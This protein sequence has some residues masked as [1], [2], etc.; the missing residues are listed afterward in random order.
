MDYSELAEALIVKLFQYN[1][2]QS[3]KISPMIHGEIMTLN[4]LLDHKCAATPGAISGKMEL[5][6]A[7]VA[8]L[9]RSLEHRG[10][11]ERN[12]DSSD[13]RRVLVTVTEKGAAL[14][15]EHR[16]EMRDKTARVLMQLG[17]ADARECLR[18]LD[19]ILEIS[20][21][22]DTDDSNF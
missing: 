1:K 10:L 22:E 14:T 12:V 19:R 6:T 13:R 18:I 21:M 4:F 5:S 16:N 17:E 2:R 9:L 11:I 20:L 8:K 7:Y 15:C 3:K